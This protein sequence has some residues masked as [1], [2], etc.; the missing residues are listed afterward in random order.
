MSGGGGGGD[1]PKL[2]LKLKTYKLKPLLLLES[3][4]ADILETSDLHEYVTMTI[5]TFFQL[6]YNYPPPGATASVHKQHKTTTTT[7][8]HVA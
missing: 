3:V 1:A 7:P 5:L 2:K 8:N 4:N 6:N